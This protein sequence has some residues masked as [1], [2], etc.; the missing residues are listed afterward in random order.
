[1][2]KVSYDEHGSMAATVKEALEDYLKSE[3]E[4]GK[5]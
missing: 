1:L 3:E 5:G 4:G 2:R